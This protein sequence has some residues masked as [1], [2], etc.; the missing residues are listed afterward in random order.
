MD[1]KAF[2]DLVEGVRQM[3]AIRDGK[4]KPG[5]V[6]VIRKSGSVGADQVKRIRVKLPLSQSEFA[7]LLNVSVRTVQDW[8]QGRRQPEGPAQAL[9]RVAERNPQAVLEALHGVSVPGQRPPKAKVN[10][11]TKQKP[12]AR[13]RPSPKRPRKRLDGPKITGHAARSAQSGG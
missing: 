2:S 10:P 8:E 12:P 13:K 1:K 9:L 6:R 7:A 11:V 4:M 5:R 3:K